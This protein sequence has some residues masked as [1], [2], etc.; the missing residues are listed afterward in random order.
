MLTWSPLLQRV[1]GDPRYPELLR[2]LNL[3]VGSGAEQAG[4]SAA[5]ERP[6][7]KGR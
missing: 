4:S 5:S 7:A 2:S 6:A 3:R 1:R